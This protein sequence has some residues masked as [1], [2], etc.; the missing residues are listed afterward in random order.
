MAKRSATR[1]VATNLRQHGAVKAWSALGPTRVVPDGIEILNEPT[2]S[3]VY[4]LLGVGPDGSAVVAKQRRVGPGGSLVERTAYEEVFPRL[5]V[6][7]L[8]YYGFV[9][10]DDA[11]FG[12]LFLE[13][14]GRIQYSARIEEHRALAGRWLGCLHSFG[15]GADRQRHLPDH[16]SDRYVDRLRAARTSILSNLS[17]P[18][19]TA[20]DIAVL[21]ATISLLDRLDSR[22]S[23][24][25]DL[26]GQLPLTL[27]LRNFVPRNSFVRMDQSG[28]KLLIVDCESFAWGNPVCDLAQ[29]YLPSYGRD[30][31]ASPDITAYFQVV[32]DHWP[33][34]DFETMRHLASYGTVLRCVAI[35]SWEA[36]FLG[37]DWAAMPMA[38]IRSYHAILP[39]AM[40]VAGWA[41]C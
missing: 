12:W 1:F 5:P 31:S 24:V 20:D 10:D 41:V 11:R 16:G 18:V 7:A 38:K 32:R 19:L 39:H 9:E 8:H 17:N 14:A 15:P 13:D 21:R 40:R 3:K 25:D 2:G 36:P 33:H 4:R 6:P 23:E 34:V 30:F 22:W 37:M 26:S 29:S 28:M 35:M 27:V